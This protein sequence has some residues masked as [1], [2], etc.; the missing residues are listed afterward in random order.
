M[1]AD[2]WTSKN[3]LGIDSRDDH[4]CARNYLKANGAP[5]R[6][7]QDLEEGSHFFGLSN[8]SHTGI[9][10]GTHFGAFD[11]A[12]DFSNVIA[13]GWKYEPSDGDSG[14]SGAEGAQE[15]AAIGF[16]NN[17][18]FMVMAIAGEQPGLLPRQWRNLLERSRTLP[19]PSGDVSV[20]IPSSYRMDEGKRTRLVY[21]QGD[22]MSA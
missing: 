12:F 21:Y 14:P 13:S 17:N 4:G 8:N 11:E 2:L 20:S 3:D 7:T 6:A 22:E 16:G 10:V 19:I 15:R 1:P 18:R 9:A 5:I